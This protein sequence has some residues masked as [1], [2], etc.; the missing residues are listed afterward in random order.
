MQSPLCSPPPSPPYIHVG[1]VACPVFPPLPWSYA[2]QPK[3]II[4]CI[5]CQTNESDIDDLDVY[6][7]EMSSRPVCHHGL[8]L[9]SWSP[10][11]ITASICCR[12]LDLSSWPRA[13][14]FPVSIPPLLFPA[15][16]SICSHSLCLF[17]GYVTCANSGIIQEQG[18]IFE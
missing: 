12:G 16:R 7:V 10:S 18:C 14:A 5:N 1:G 3:N 2:P 11:V 9:L 17:H 6:N 15:V 4:N 13:V 8:Y